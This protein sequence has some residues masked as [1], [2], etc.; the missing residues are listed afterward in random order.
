MCPFQGV[1]PLALVCTLIQ[2][3]KMFINFV[4][5]ERQPPKIDHNGFK[6]RKPWHD[7]EKSLSTQAVIAI[8]SS[9]LTVVNELVQLAH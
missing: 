2:F 6:K 4:E 8:R 9:V 5:D 7:K 3:D 1:L